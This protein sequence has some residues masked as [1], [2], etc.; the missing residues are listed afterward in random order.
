M[1][2]KH[3][4]VLSALVLFLI[5]P[6]TVLLSPRV[7]AQSEGFVGWNNVHSMYVRADFTD[8]NASG[9]QS[10][11][12]GATNSGANMAFYLPAN[13]AAVWRI[14]CDFAYSQATVVA[15][16]FGVTFSNAPTNTM[17][18][19]EMATN[20]TAFAS[21]TPVNITVNTNTTIVTGTPA[22]TTVLGAHI[23]GYVEMPSTATPT[24]VQ[25][26]ITQSTAANVIV[27]KRDSGCTWHSM[28]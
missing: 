13:V 15:D 5:A 8:A 14:D 1:K 21:I 25:W 12:L 10:I 3:L 24:S 26:T 28:A 22:V 2:L 16:S 20:V 18:W 9:A 19:G 23:W 27:I 7:H 17:L 4:I 11:L 6:F